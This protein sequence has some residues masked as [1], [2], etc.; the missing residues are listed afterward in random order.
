MSCLITITIE[1]ICFYVHECLGMNLIIISNKVEN[2]WYSIF[3]FCGI[4]L[5][6]VALLCV[7][8]LFAS[9]NCL[10]VKRYV[11]SGDIQQDEIQ[12]HDTGIKIILISDLHD[13]TFGKDNKYLINRV[14]K[15]QPDLILMAGDFLEAESVSDEVAVSLIRSLAGTAPVY[16]SLGNQEQE[17]EKTH[18]DLRQRIAEAGAVFME[19]EYV[20]LTVRG[21]DLRLGGMYNYAFHDDGKG[22]MDKSGINPDTRA[23]LEDFQDTDR[24]K[25]MMAHRPDSF[26]FSDAY[27]TWDIDLVVSGH[28]H[29]GQVIIPFAGGLFAGDQGFFPEY[30]YGLYH[31]NGVKNMVITRGLGSGKERLPRFNN[32]PEIVGIVLEP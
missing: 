22:H 10:T 9:V 3:R 16:Y 26:I 5:L 1:K 13:H 18:P 2:R 25:I 8:S 15:L 11:L 12:D 14:Q 20:D 24:Y 17:F 28:L 7:V 31:F 6:T 32:I 4:V 30:D 29:G 19:E 23:F 27:D 21:C